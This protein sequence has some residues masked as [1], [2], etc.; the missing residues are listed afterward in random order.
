[1]RKYIID[2]DIGDDIDDIFALY[3]AIKDKSLDV[4]G[5]TTVFKNSALRARMAKK[6]LKLLGREDIPVYAGYGLPLDERTP[7]P[8]NTKFCQYTSDLENKE[9]DYDNVNEGCQGESAVDFIIESAKK[10]RNDLTVIALGP[11]TN[12][13]KAILKAPDIMK[14][15]KIIIMGGAYYMQYREWNIICDVAAAKIV[16]DSRIDLSCVGYDV[17]KDIQPGRKFHDKVMAS[18]GDGDMGYLYEVVR[19]WTEDYKRDII[20]HDPLTIYYAIYPERIFMEKVPVYLETEGKYGKGMTFNLDFQHQYDDREFE[21][22]VNCAKAVDKKVFIRYF[23]KTVF[24][25]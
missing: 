19:L 20:L 16:F 4:I 14:D 10:Y 15:I 9:Y 22:K 2:T 25:E 7:V 18:Y 13:A 1:M 3:F 5:V 17:T 11:Q 24:G 6:S 23:I 8:T 21:N 12:L